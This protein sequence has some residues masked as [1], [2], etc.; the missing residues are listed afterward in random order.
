M[1][2]SRFGGGGLRRIGLAFEHGLH[3]V[4]SAIA[5]A[6]LAEAIGCAISHGKV[7]KCLQ[8]GASPTSQSFSLRP[9]FEQGNNYNDP[10]F[11][12]IVWPTFDEA[13]LPR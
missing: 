4:D 1:C 7:S 13:H 5:L 9:H 6:R 2:R 8:R 11:L 10:P 3:S 12:K